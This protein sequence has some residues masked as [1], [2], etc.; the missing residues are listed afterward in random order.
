M[1]LRVSACG[2]CHSDLDIADRYFDLVQGQKLDL[3]P[4][5]KLRRPSGSNLTLGALR[6]TAA[7]ILSRRRGRDC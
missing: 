5:V 1:L 3:A 4:A 2:V 7:M 6:L